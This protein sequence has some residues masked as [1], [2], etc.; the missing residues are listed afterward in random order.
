VSSDVTAIVTGI[1]DLLKNVRQGSLLQAGM[2]IVLAG[3][4]NAGKSSLLNALAAEDAAIVSPQPGTTRDIIRTRVDIDGMPLHVLDTAGLRTSSDPIEREG[5]ARAQTAMS[6]A[7]RTLIVVDD[8]VETSFDDSVSHVP[9]G[10]SISIVYNKIDLTGRVAGDQPSDPYPAIAVSAKTGAG[11][12]A[13]RI[14]LKACMGFQPAG[15]GSFIARRRHVVAIEEARACLESGRRALS[16]RGAGELLA[17]ELRRAQKYLG[18]LT[19]EFTSDELLGR[20][21]ASF[22]IGK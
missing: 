13:L 22:C 1:D 19:G 8:S 17:E 6:R 4:P 14:H 3:A 20:I 2:T 7:D 18:E 21:F 16:D 15:E 5:M 9:P 11:L 12:D 10:I